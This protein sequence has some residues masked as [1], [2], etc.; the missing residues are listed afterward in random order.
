MPQPV[1]L[2]VELARVT[3]ADRVQQVAD[4]LSL[5][6]QQRMAA[7]AEQDGVNHETQVQ[8]TAQ[9]QSEGVDVESH[10]QNPFVGRRRKRATN[11]N[12]E[13]ATKDDT[14]VAADMPVVPEA[15]SEGSRLD[16]SV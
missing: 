3:A 9:S 1:D 6:A 13:P 11:E 16:I 7:E 14:L 8:E 15:Q 12:P 5:A 2:Q 10:R 4:R